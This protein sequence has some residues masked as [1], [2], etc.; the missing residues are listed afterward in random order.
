MVYHIAIFN[1]YFFT[2]WGAMTDKMS[3]KICMGS[4]C[5]SRGNL[6][7]KEIIEDFIRSRGLENRIDFRGD[8]C[9][10]KCEEGPNV[11]IGGK[12]YQQVDEEV[13]WDILE[14]RFAEIESEQADTQADIDG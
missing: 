14:N 6:R 11:T 7:V 1:E 9:C 8:L 13:I 4:S 12:E 5:Y 2:D 3:I 10:G